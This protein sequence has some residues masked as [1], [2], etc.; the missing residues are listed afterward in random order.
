MNSQFLDNDNSKNSCALTP[1]ILACETAMLLGIRRFSEISRNGSNM[2][3]VVGTARQKVGAFLRFD[4][5]GKA[6]LT[7]SYRRNRVEVQVEISDLYRSLN[8]FSSRFLMPA[9][10]LLQAG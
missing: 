3:V 10:P 7:L 6:L 5:D 4:G 2:Q 8:L 9:I 1:Y